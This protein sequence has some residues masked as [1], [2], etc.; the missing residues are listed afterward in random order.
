MVFISQYANWLT[1]LISRCC[2]INIMYK[3][4]SL[5][6]VV[7]CALAI[8]LSACSHNNV[9]DL[10]A[11][12]TDVKAK[13]HAGIEPLPNILSYATYTYDKAELRDP[14]SPTAA[15]KPPVTQCSQVVRRRDP[16]EDFSLEALTMVGSL[17]QDGERWALIRSQDGVIHRRK[18]F[19]YIGKDNGHI[20]KITET[21]IELRESISQG[22]G[23]VNKTTILSMA[24]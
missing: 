7:Y 23:C 18:T 3:S 11:Y 9:S 24:E 4:N 17:E 2:S 14:F 6:S 15:V 13:Q 16:L 22:D 5:S 1:D 12:V 21:S 8:I 19:D 10:Q 20:R